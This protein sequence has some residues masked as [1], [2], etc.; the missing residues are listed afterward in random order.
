[1][2]IQAQTLPSDIALLQQLLLEQQALLEAKDCKIAELTQTYQNLLEQFRLAQHKRFGRSSEAPPDQGELFN[3]AEVL[4]DTPDDKPID[5]T[6][7]TSDN[8]KQPKR[9]PLPKDLPRKQVIHDISDD[10]KQCECCAHE[11]ERMGQDVSEKLEFI[12]A[13]VQVIEHVRLK[14][15]CQHCE[16]HGTQSNIKQAP[17]PKSPIPKGY[18]TPSLLSQIITSKYQYA[19]PLYRQEIMFKQHG[20]DI[21]RRTMADWMMKCGALF[22][23]LY[24]RLQEILLEQPVIQAD[25]TTL[26]VIN[27]E[28]YKS[29]IW[30]YC[31]GTDSLVAAKSDD[32]PVVRNIALF[33][34]QNGSRSGSCVS[35]YLQ[36]FGDV[37]KETIPAIPSL[38]RSLES[39][40]F[41][42]QSRRYDK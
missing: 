7:T 17:V 35:R 38:Q 31:S 25:E 13:K 3:E 15:S 11:L 36:E 30:V 18:A 6:P 12:P 26:K 10:E 2:K 14:Y 32:D 20:I 28:R 27:D 1:M 23:P 39:S 21:N 19:L 4:V 24:K 5:T 42:E 37:A 9:K 29:Y 41:L 33:D 22:K 16:K 8:K 40:A 34:Y